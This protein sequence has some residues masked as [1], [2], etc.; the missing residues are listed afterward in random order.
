MKLPSDERSFREHGSRQPV[1][2][3]SMVCA[4]QQSM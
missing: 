3:D 4:L 2:I 1:D